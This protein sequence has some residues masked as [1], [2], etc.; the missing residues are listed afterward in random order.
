MQ[1]AL[2]AEQQA[3]AHAR[4]L[5]GGEHDRLDAAALGLV[6]DRLAG[7]AGAHDRRGDLD[8]LV[9]LA[10]RLG[11]LQRRAGALEL[12][13]GHA[14]VERQRHR[15]LEDPQRLD[16]RAALAVVVVLLGGEP[17]GGLHDVVVERR[18]EDRHE[19]RAVLGLGRRARVSA[20][21]GTV[22]RLRT[23]LPSRA[24]GSRRRATIPNAIQPSADPA[25]A[26]VL[27]EQR[28]ER[29]ARTSARTSAAGH[30]QLAAA[31]RAR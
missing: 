14:R 21:S 24:C 28:D 18:A 25:R 23:G 30:R 26:A 20:A 15:H 9:L 3:A 6:H 27:D 16:H 7:A 17:A 10:D 12:L 29:G 8:A 22:T 19:D 2:A 13:V 1:P 4:R 11:A 31:R 5:L